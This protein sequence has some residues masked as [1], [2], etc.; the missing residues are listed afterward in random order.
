MAKVFREPLA[1]RLQGKHDSRQRCSRASK[2]TKFKNLS[3]TRSDPTANRRTRTSHINSQKPEGGAASTDR[4][5][6]ICVAR[7]SE[8]NSREVKTGTAQKT[9]AACERSGARLVP[10]SPGTESPAYQKKEKASSPI[11][12][13]PTL[14]YFGYLPPRSPDIA[15]LQQLLLRS[16]EEEWAEFTSAR[17]LGN[18]PRGGTVRA[19]HDWV[20][21]C[22]CLCC[23]KAM[24]YH[25]SEDDSDDCHMDASIDPC[26]CQGPGTGCAGRWGILGVLSVCMPCLLCY[27]L[28]RAFRGASQRL[29]SKR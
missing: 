27:P 29:L 3:R 11:S 12:E 1:T 13:E 4:R 8:S 14:R 15:T 23:V 21:C 24:F 19:D 20:D 17:L 5:Y 18:E 7:C 16:E 28:I 25:C 9:Y 6:Q 10:K 22:T 26:S 2:N